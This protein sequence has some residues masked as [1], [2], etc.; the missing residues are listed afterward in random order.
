MRAAGLEV[1]IRGG[2]ALVAPQAVLGV[3]GDPSSA[4]VWACA[5]A[6][7]PGSAVVLDQVGLNPYRLGF[8][9]ALAR[10]GATIERRQ[11][12]LLTGEP[13]GQLRI[14][15]AGRT[16]RRPSR[17]TR[18]RSHRRAAGPWRARAALEGGLEVRGAGELRVKESDRITALVTGFRGARCLGAGTAGRLHHRGRSPAKPGAPPTRRAT[19]ASSWPLRSS[20]S[21][22]AGRP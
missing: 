22:R 7:L 3:P 11:E 19:I 8:L 14:G 13:V 21:A 9:A 1:S 16:S 2:Q 5:A 20:A 10:M 12:A 17:P 4:A 6:A 18:S 15:H